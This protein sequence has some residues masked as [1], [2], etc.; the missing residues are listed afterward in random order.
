MMVKTIMQ[1]FLI[2]S[3]NVTTTTSIRPNDTLTLYTDHPPF[4]H[5]PSILFKIP[6]W[7]LQ[8]HGRFKILFFSLVYLLH[9][10]ACPRQKK[11]CGADR[12]CALIK[13]TSVW[14]IGVQWP[15]QFLVLAPE[16]TEQGAGRSQH[17]IQAAEPPERFQITGL[18][19]CIWFVEYL[20]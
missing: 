19:V 1:F 11:Q 2:K 4:H 7:D 18:P 8:F 9:W 16:A 3:F 15:V 5:T 14:L 13:L 12:R 6:I 17:R 10:V 20:L